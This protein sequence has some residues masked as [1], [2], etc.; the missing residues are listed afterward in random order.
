M[1]PCTHR[2]HVRHLWV[3]SYNPGERVTP[4]DCHL[5]SSLCTCLS[6]KRAAQRTK[7]TYHGADRTG[8]DKAEP[9]VLQDIARTLRVPALFHSPNGNFCVTAFRCPPPPKTRLCPRQEALLAAVRESGHQQRQRYANPPAGSALPPAGPAAATGEG[10]LG[11]D[12][13]A[14]GLVKVRLFFA[15]CCC[16]S[17]AAGPAATGCCSM[18]AARG[19]TA[20]G[21]HRGKHHPAVKGYIVVC[22]V[23]AYSS[24][25][26]SC[27]PIV[28]RQSPAPEFPL[29]G[30]RATSSERPLEPPLGFGNGLGA[31]CEPFP[32]PRTGS[33]AT[34]LR[35]QPPSAF[36][37]G[38]GIIGLIILTRE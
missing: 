19:Y 31:L 11:S 2:W 1:A 37:K 32:K 21:V 12:L 14:L 27:A 16:T 4:L 36:Y 34:V 9:W 29:F 18:V 5:C 25:S 15:F 28:N 33:D 10:A 8:R 13:A 24:A 6:E 23:G 17:G 35:C 3:P 7:C 26:C 22:I 20:H 30:T 38:Q